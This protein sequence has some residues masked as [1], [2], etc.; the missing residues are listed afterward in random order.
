MIYVPFTYKKEGGPLW[1]ITVGHFYV[2]TTKYLFQEEINIVRG[3][4]GACFLLSGAMQ[5]YGFAAL[6]S[7]SAELRN[8][9]FRKFVT[10]S[11]VVP[12]ASWI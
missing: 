7:T 4:R 12:E 5:G 9:V 1:V 6:R 8:Q 11:L 10:A 3:A 2:I